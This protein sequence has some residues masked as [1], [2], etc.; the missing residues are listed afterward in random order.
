M[1]FAVHCYINASDDCF[2]GEFKDMVLDSSNIFSLV[3]D[4]Q[5]SRRLNVLLVGKE[6]ISSQPMECTFL[7]K[8]KASKSGCVS[9]D[10]TEIH[11]I[12]Y[13]FKPVEKHVDAIVCLYDTHYNFTHFFHDIKHLLYQPGLTTYFVGLEKNLNK[14]IFHNHTKDI[15]NKV[16]FVISLKTKDGLEELIQKIV[17]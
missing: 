16:S 3:I 8:I 11:F 14:K 1:E 5:P 17:E 7:K 2:F 6:F 13:R 15:V 9:L 12:E 4:F 10:S